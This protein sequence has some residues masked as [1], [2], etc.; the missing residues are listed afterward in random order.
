MSSMYLKKLEQLVNRIRVSICGP[1]PSGG[2]NSVELWHVHWPLTHSI[3]L[4]VFISDI[5]V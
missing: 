1:M 2:R 3:Y 4:L 5:E